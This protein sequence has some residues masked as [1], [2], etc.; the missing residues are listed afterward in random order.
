MVV[1]VELRYKNI[2]VGGAS[3]L[4]FQRQEADPVTC[5]WYASPDEAVRKSSA[6]DVS[7]EGLKAK[8][9]LEE[10]GLGP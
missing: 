7:P 8:R 5:Y 3:V 4:V 10:G 1:H 2:Q 6:D 9:I